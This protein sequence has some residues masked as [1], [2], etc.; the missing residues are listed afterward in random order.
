M[1]GVTRSDC[2]ACN[3]LLKGGCAQVEIDRNLAKEY[4]KEYQTGDGFETRR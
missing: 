3:G 4:A 1:P 2:G